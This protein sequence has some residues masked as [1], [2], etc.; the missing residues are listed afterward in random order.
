MTVICISKNTW[1]AF[2]NNAALH[3]LYIINTCDQLNENWTSLH[4]CQTS[5][6]F[7]LLFRVNNNQWVLKISALFYGSSQSNSNEKH[8]KDPI[9]EKLQAFVIT[10]KGSKL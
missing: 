8:C 6:I 3:I 5:F 2:P 1:S 9:E 4:F 7:S 10:Y